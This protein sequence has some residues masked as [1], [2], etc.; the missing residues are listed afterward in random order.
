MYHAS[1]EVAMKSKLNVFSFRNL[2]IELDNP[3]VVAERQRKI[4][5]AMI[6]PV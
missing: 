5:N 1:V 4:Y 3:V 6:H 2:E